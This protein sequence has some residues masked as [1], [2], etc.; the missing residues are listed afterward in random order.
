VSS[1]GATCGRRF[2]P[3]VP[4]GVGGPSQGWRPRQPLTRPRT[5]GESGQRGSRTGKPGGCP[6][7][8]THQQW[9]PQ[10]D[11]H[12][13]ATP[14]PLTEPVPV[15]PA[16]VGRRL[17]GWPQLTCRPQNR[18]R[19]QAGGM[20]GPADSLTRERFDIAGGIAH[21][22][23]PITASIDHWCP[24]GERRRGS[25]D[26]GL[27]RRSVNQFGPG[28][29]RLSQQIGDSNCGG[30]RGR[31]AGWNHRRSEVYPAILQSHQSAVARSAHGHHQPAR[32]QAAACRRQRRPEPDAVVWWS[33][34]VGRPAAVR[35]FDPNCVGQ[36]TCQHEPITSEALV[37]AVG[38]RDADGDAGCGWSAAGDAGPRQP[39]GSGVDG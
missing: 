14:V 23:D 29:T 33:S 30:F 15:L 39:G 28:T 17:S 31:N 27:D 10:R 8:G 4:C 13:T 26:G 2:V 38:R 12:E 24:V 3:R 36:A 19:Q 35:R 32:R 20:E 25:D 16:V 7:G 5:G 34:P 11:R 1:A 18:L 21:P 6:D 22:I 37:A 9:A